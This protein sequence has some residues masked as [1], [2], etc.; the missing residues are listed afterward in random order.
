[1]EN[2]PEKTMDNEMQAG[3]GIFY[4]RSQYLDAPLE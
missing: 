1:M 3:I 2:Q 4:I